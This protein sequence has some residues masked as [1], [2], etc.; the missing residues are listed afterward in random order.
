[1]RKRIRC[2]LSLL[3]IFLTLFQ[4]I[5]IKN[6]PII[7][8]AGIVQ[9][10]I[11]IDGST[12]DW[13]NASPIITGNG[14]ITSISS[15]QDDERIYILIEGTNLNVLSNIYIDSDNE[16]LT[17]FHSWAWQNSGIDYMVENS[18]L[19]CY[20]GTGSDWSWTYSGN[21]VVVKT[22]SI[23]ELSIGLSQIGRN[24]P[25]DMRL[26][27]CRDGAD[28]LP[29]TGSEMSFIHY[30]NT[31]DDAI[32]YEKEE[33]KSAGIINTDGKLTL[34]SKYIQPNKF[35]IYYGELQYSGITDYSKYDFLIVYDRNVD[36]VRKVRSQGCKIFQYLYFGSRFE[37][38]D[39]FIND[40]KNQILELKNNGLAD[41]VFLDECDTDYWE[42]GYSR[43]P[44]KCRVF[45]NKLK[46]VTEYCRSI[47][48]KTVVNGSRAFC[49]L[50]DYYLWESFQGFWTTNSLKWSNAASQRSITSLGEI[51]YGFL[52]SDWTL[53]GSCYYDGQSIRGGENGSAEILIDMDHIVEPQD[54][55]NIYDWVYFEW[56]GTGADDNSCKIW[57]WTGDELPFNE[58][59]W[60][61]TWR[62]LPKLWKGEAESWNGIGKS[63]RYLKIRMEFSGADNL[64]IDSILLTYDYQYPY[65]DMTAANGEADINPYLWNYN[66]SQRNYL[67]DKIRETGNKVRVLTHS[68]GNSVDEYK[69]RYAY[70]SSAIW[71]FYSC[72]YVHP[73]MQNIYENSVLDEPIGMFL[74][75]T[76][77]NT[78]VFTGATASVDLQNNIYTLQ[79]EEPGYWYDRAVMVDGNT[80]EWEA[81]NILYQH[82]GP[83]FS[84][85]S[86]WW[87]AG[88]S[89]YHEG[90]FDNTKVENRD[91]NDVLELVTDGSGTWTSPVIKAYRADAKGLMNYI[92]W[93]YGNGNARY[94]CRYKS[95]D[96]NWT[97]WIDITNH[98][99]SPMVDFTEF[100][101][102]V[103]L[104]G[105]ASYTEYV[106]QE[107]GNGGVIKEE[108]YYQGVSFWGS[109]HTWDLYLPDNINVKNFMVNDD[110]E[111]FYIS[112]EV[113]GQIDFSHN[114]NLSSDF[115]YNIYLNTVGNNNRGYIGEW[116]KTDFGADYRI[117]NSGIF[118]WDNTVGDRTDNNGWR[119]IGSPGMT[120]RLSDDKKTI[121]YRIKK[122]SLG[123]LKEKELRLFM[124]VD[125][126]K[127]TIG[128]LINPFESEKTNY[129]GY[130]VYPQKSYQMKSPH[131]WY[132]SEEKDLK[133]EDGNVYL[134][135]D[136]YRPEGTDVKAWIRT[137]KENENWNDWQEVA[138]GIPIS[139]SFDKIQYCFGL[140]TEN[141]NISPAVSGIELDTYQ[142]SEEPIIKVRGKTLTY[143][144]FS[145]LVAVENT[146]PIIVS[147]TGPNGYS[148]TNTY[149][150]QNT[151]V[152]IQKYLTYPGEY[153]I[154]VNCS[155]KQTEKKITIG[156]S[157]FDE[158]YQ[159]LELIRYDRECSVVF[160]DSGEEELLFEATQNAYYTMFALW[161]ND[162]VKNN[163]YVSVYLA[164]RLLD[165]DMLSLDDIRNIKNSLI[166]SDSNANVHFTEWDQKKEDERT[167]LALNMIPFIGG[168]KGFIEGVEGYDL[169]TGRKLAWW[170][171]A[172][173]I[174]A[175]TLE[176]VQFV[177]LANVVIREAKAMPLLL[178][179]EVTAG[180][181][182]QA[183]ADA[184]INARFSK[185][186]IQDLSGFMDNMA[187]VIN[188]AG[189]SVDQFYQLMPVSADT[190]SAADKA[191]MK[192]I[193]D[194][195][196]MPTNETILQKVIPQVDIAKYLDGTYTDIRGYI[197]KAQDVKQ[198]ITYED[199]YYSFRF[200]YTGSAFNP[201][202]DECMGVIRFQAPDLQHIGIP[203]SPAMGGN[204][205]DG[206]PF[207]GNA[208]I[209]AK[210]GQAIPEFKVTVGEVL[211]LDDGA[212]L[213]VVT[214]EGMEKLVA[215]Y[216]QSIGRFVDLLK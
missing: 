58:D 180:R 153:T 130:F 110:N 168:I 34:D 26:S 6:Q 171:C 29:N 68:Y 185:A 210:N 181:I 216:D 92:Y 71:G 175:G 72:D 82:A 126:S 198:L 37:N 143:T 197:A 183:A 76:D 81:G 106:E 131:G 46:E 163:P 184:M 70:L 157:D 120:Y 27:F 154:I 88:T 33:S 21:I 164:T 169:V 215:V 176:T 156:L 128:N 1:M 129:E 53:S 133:L 56:F 66:N 75:R 16:G 196:P 186:T 11:K 54:R 49:D 187:S 150:R 189:L 142:L 94:Q 114:P 121:E 124:Q 73:M 79:R 96:G 194:S 123:G 77:D 161:E 7:T 44:E 65:R 127:S 179:L 162:I 108:V 214:R 35:N 74:K 42:I 19:Y 93:N 107:D 173:G 52:L 64:K 148:D 152:N 23:I 22:D 87:G 199:Y 67:W 202:T 122:E 178:R 5:I 50:G 62:K 36:S 47:G 18:N 112:Y 191:A 137:R 17:G 51:N 39:T 28:Y 61:N 95:L 91:G 3:M 10:K 20:T 101:V 85:Y 158:A 57:V 97:D 135:W 102:K 208:F 151:Y 170:E 59:T 155:G 40:F 125:E 136:E 146:E 98:S 212:E 118:Q 138:N 12:D 113:E 209:A 201:A 205:T 45:Y 200:D 32:K 109:S 105:K 160:A 132:C 13:V 211:N 38:T 166:A 165:G 193:R 43:D 195:I 182:S 41:G 117:S 177:K 119:W 63:S 139:A 190:L 25:G 78:G 213:Y 203:Y 174:I 55:K 149:Y 99:S 30:T 144:P 60:D 116:W 145:L 167:S 100:Q 31:N 24:L 188:D 8:Y 86:Q 206:P 134:N 111:Y 140:F 15:I 103:E 172:V 14:N 147:I 4:S 192:M 104:T 83:S 115:N 9:S 48:V 69:K 80:D 141:G 90:I 159:M 207:T 89:T 204:V 2:S 84:A